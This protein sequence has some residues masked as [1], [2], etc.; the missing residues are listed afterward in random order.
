MNTTPIS[1]SIE[2]VSIKLIRNPIWKFP[3]LVKVKKATERSSGFPAC[4]VLPVL[5]SPRR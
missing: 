5:S 3:F 4:R 2:S 1:T